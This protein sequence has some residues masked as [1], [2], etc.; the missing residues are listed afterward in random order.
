MSTLAHTQH[1]FQS[2]L[3][4]GEG[5][6]DQEVIGTERVPVETRLGI[7]AHAYRARLVEALQANYPALAALLGETE[8]AELGAAYIE[9]YDSTF[10][11]VRYYGHALAGFLAGDA[12]Y[13]GAPLLADLARWEWAMTEVFDAADAQS[14][15]PVAA[16]RVPP[17]EWATLRFTFH[18]SLRRLDLC[19]NAPQTW[20]A[21]TEGGSRPPAGMEPAPVSWLLW[22]RELTTH[23]RS[24]TTAE[25]RALDLAREGTPFGD[26]CVELC[27]YGPQSEAPAQAAAF[28]RQW[29]GSGLIVGLAR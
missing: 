12:R 7:Y 22:R 11:S 19:W 10:F 3:L 1:A 9:A 17:G 4:R 15:E 6:I 16:E 13:S 23:Y 14:L 5:G 18:P 29:F 20:K 27:R 26:L 25:A 2:F 28:L 21:L 8:F 24:I